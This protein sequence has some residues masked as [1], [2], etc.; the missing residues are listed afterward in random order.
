[1]KADCIWATSLAFYST[2]RSTIVEL[3]QKEVA[4][5]LQGD[6]SDP[7]VP[8]VSAVHSAK[9]RG[10]AASSVGGIAIEATATSDTAVFAH[11]DSGVGVDARSNTGTGLFAH[12]DNSIALEASATKDT[13]VFAHSQTG[14]GVDAR[15]G[16]DPNGN[17]GDH[18]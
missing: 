6:S 1:M 12:S 15:S 11:S 7:N 13:A 16:T 18:L 9:G 17:P 10:V 2:L 4:I 8:A 14:L 5:N 3:F